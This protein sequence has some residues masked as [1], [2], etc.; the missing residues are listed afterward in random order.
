MS[1]SITVHVK[2][3]TPVVAGH[4]GHIPDGTF[5]VNGH[6]EHDYEDLSVSRHNAEPGKENYTRPVAQ[7]STRASR[8]HTAH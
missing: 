4:S 5:S 1:Y 8:R 6:H 2:D 7:A 3:G